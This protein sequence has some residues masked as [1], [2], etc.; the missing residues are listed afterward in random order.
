MLPLLFIQRKE[1]LHHLQS[2]LNDISCSHMPMVAKPVT[3]LSCP[4]H[5]D[6]DPVQP[7]LLLSDAEKQISNKLPLICRY[8]RKQAAQVP[9]ECY[10]PLFEMEL[11]YRQSQG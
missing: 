11:P 6:E 1:L 2:S 5:H 8:K 7:H 9:R 4:L 10:S 3:C